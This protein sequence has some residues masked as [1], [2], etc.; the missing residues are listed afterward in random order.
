MKLILLTS[1]LLFFS[2]N[3]FSQ[4]KDENI[5]NSSKKLN[6]LEQKKSNST[7]DS[8][9]ID[10]PTSVATQNSTV[11]KRNQEWTIEKLD[12]YIAD[13]ET[14]VQWVKNNPEEDKAA[15]ASGWYNE[16]ETNINNAKIKKAAIIQKQ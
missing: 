7:Q 2:S 3:I 15:K 11:V 16:M 4:K 12:K 13:I 8:L 6:T 1:C 9:S 10:K 14:K 5:S